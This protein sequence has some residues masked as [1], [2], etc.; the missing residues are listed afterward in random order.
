MRWTH[1]VTD[2]ALR[3]EE[4]QSGWTQQFV[5]PYGIKPNLGSNIFIADLHLDTTIE[6]ALPSGFKKVTR[7]HTIFFLL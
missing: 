2:A 3:M 1:K 5:L 7:W 4:E 6:Q